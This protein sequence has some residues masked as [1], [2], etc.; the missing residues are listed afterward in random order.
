MPALIR[1][2]R[3]IKVDP[4]DGDLYS[5]FFAKPEKT[6]LEQ[7]FQLLYF[8]QR[9]KEKEAPIKVER[10]AITEALLAAKVFTDR[11]FPDRII[12]VTL[13][14]RG[15]DFRYT[16]H[17]EDREVRFPLN[18]GVGFATWE[19]GKC[20][21]ASELVFY[22]GFSFRLEQSGDNL[23]VD[24]FDKVELFGDFGSRGLLHFDLN[25]VDLEKVEFI[26]GTDQGKVKTRVARREFEANRHSFLFRFV[27]RIIPDTS[28]QRIDW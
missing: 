17:F 4:H 21:V 10:P 25:Y 23:V 3:A 16:V 24:D 2:L 13:E 27:G 20:Q 7:F 9:Q 15:K 11:S 5:I 26:A 8:I 28:R 1:S 18:Q 22:D 6:K 19:F 14:H 12:F